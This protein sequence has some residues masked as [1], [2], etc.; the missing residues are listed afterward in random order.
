MTLC[1]YEGSP[2]GRGTELG[3]Q[4]KGDGAEGVRRSSPPPLRVSASSDE[5]QYRGQSDAIQVVNFAI[6]IYI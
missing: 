5:N 1:C 3:A 4:W 6:T 2:V